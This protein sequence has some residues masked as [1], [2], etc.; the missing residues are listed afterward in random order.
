MGL[1]SPLKDKVGIGLVYVTLSLSL[2]K[3][4]YFGNLQ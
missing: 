3:W 2:R 4:V 1:V